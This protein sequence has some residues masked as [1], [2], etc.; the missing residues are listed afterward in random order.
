MTTTISVAE[1]A[2]PMVADPAE[3][4]L[5]LW[6]TVALLAVAVLGGTALR[7]VPEHHRIVVFRLGRIT[8]VRGPGIVASIPGLERVATVSLRPVHLPLVVSALT[9]DGVS[10]RLTA[11]VACR[12]AAP[13]RSTVASA[14]PV[15]DT[16]ATVESALAKRVA[17][18]DLVDLLMV[19]E[20]LEDTL[21]CELSTIAAAWGV[22]VAE[23]TVSDIEARLSADL[24][25]LV[26]QAGT[27]LSRPSAGRRSTPPGDR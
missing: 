7:V 13:A 4:S 17:H 1:A 8:R 9:R 10:V 14:D 2:R 6:L 3:W 15:G 18:T 5:G 20:R 21:P 12:I 19:R 27:P 23:I 24:L 25:R 11:T 26:Q 16:V 22:E